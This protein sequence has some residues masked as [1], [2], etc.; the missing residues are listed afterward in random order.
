MV[1]I[2]TT[3]DLITR[4][5]RGKYMAYSSMG[6]TVGPAIGPI[7]GGI[8]TRYLGWR[9]NFWFL[10][11]LTAV[12]IL[13]FLLFLRETCRAVVGNGSLSAQPWNR[14][15][16]EMIRPY[17]YEHPGYDT[18]VT[19]RRGPGL[20]DSLS[21]M[22]S[23]SMCVLILGGTLLFCGSMAVTSSIPT[24]LERKYGFDSL[25]IGLCYLPYSAGGIAARWT[26]GTLMDWNFRRFGRNVVVEVQRN[27]QSTK[28]LRQ[29]PLERVRLQLTLPLVYLSSS[30]I[31]GYGWVMNYDVHLAGPLIIL[32]LFGNSNTA[33]NN[34]L[35]TLVVDLNAYRPATAVAAT[36]L[37]KF[38]SGAGM[39][40]G[41]LPL[42]DAVGISWV[43]TIIAG[44]W[45]LISPLLW[46]LYIYGQ[47]W[48]E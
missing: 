29:I 34:S 32:F 4:A 46:L 45:C 27:Q 41:V 3:S 12:I 17:T 18:R 15:A 14:P 31:L 36:N 28:Q 19:F 23:K 35:N 6:Y 33:V 2:A 5:E 22:K 24:L 8:L 7:V 26:M 42:I 9:S 40:T 21:V 44:F 48:S 30:C 39:M 43:G 10:A 16:L 1:A 25:Q 11:I 20:L 38:M 47:E 13:V 37:L